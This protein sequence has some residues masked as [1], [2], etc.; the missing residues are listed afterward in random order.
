MDK[1]RDQKRIEMMRE[2]FGDGHDAFSDE[3]IAE[4]V[5]GTFAVAK[6]DLKIAMDE[7]KGKISKSINLTALITWALILIGVFGFWGGLGYSIYLNI[8]K[9]KEIENLNA[10]MEWTTKQYNKLNHEK[11]ELE[12]SIPIRGTCLERV[13]VWEV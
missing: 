2:W 1:S 13:T 9:D 12:K 7:L 10:Q 5:G 4:Y 8:Q 3:A 6:I 11:N